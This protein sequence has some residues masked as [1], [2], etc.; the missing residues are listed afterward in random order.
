VEG[1]HNLTD[2]LTKL[3]EWRKRLFKPHFLQIPNKEWLY[4]LQ[5]DTRNSIMIEG[6]FV[7]EE[8][9]EAVLTERYRSGSEVA[10]YFKTAKFFYNLALEVARTSEEVPCLT[11]VK[12]AHRMLFE[13][14]IS[15][16]RK[17]GDF[18]HGP[19]R[20]TGAKI[21][22]PEYDLHDWVRLWCDYVRFAYF[23]HPVHEATARAHV[24]FE[25]IHP[26]E[27]G[28]GRIGRILMNF[29]LLSNGYVNIVIKG[30]EKKE[31]DEYIKA[32]AEAERGI[33]EIF[34][35][36]T[37]KYTPESIDECFN[38]K[39]TRRLSKLIADALIESYDR[40]ICSMNAEKLITVEEYAKITG[41]SSEAVRKLIGRKRLI[42]YKPQGRWHI[43][44]ERMQSGV[45]M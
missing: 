20:I 9:L 27:D 8:E 7:S 13:N 43:Y 25:S 2:P 40:L 37:S 21:K 19:I 16:S 17:L 3:I 10:N 45:R 31:R 5:Q 36:P 26:F 1:W 28:N 41:K 30:V 38:E 35:G 32:L 15:D 42:A 22:P 4:M 34:V 18:R 6:M 29:F 24:F 12:T 44:P 33:R 39:D 23:E 11:L 14:I